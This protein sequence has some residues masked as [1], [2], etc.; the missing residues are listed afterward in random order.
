MA[1]E[2]S[3]R[4]PG[5][6]ESVQVSAGS[7]GD[8]FRSRLRSC[9]A[10]FPAGVRTAFREFF[11]D[12]PGASWGLRTTIF[13]GHLLFLE[14]EARAGG[15]HAQHGVDTFV[16]RDGLIQAQTAQYTLTPNK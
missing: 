15:N 10:Y 13:A 6:R 11:A 2:T 12:L 14:W 4:Q 3:T 5:I 1:R 7:F 8:P 9:G 16:F